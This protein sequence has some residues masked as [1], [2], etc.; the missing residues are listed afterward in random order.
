MLKTT[1]IAG[2]VAGALAFA[3]AAQAETTD[4]LQRTVAPQTQGTNAYLHLVSNNQYQ[5]HRCAKFALAVYNLCLDQA[6]G[7]SAKVRRCRAEYQRG[8]VSCQNLL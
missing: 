6:N 3:G 2:T 4:G 1:L 7:E 5:Y 8:V